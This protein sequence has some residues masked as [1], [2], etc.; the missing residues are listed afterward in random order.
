MEKNNA[1]KNVLQYAVRTKNVTHFIKFVDVLVIHHV[2]GTQRALSVI[3]LPR[4]A[5]AVLR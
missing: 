2:R 3:K 4:N 1:L 5:N